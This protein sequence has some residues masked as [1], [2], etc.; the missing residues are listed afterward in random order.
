[1]LRALQALS[2]QTLPARAFEVI[3][4]IDGSRDR[5]SE[6]VA[7]FPAPYLLR[8]LWQPNS[9]RASA[10]NSGILASCGK[11]TVLLDDDMEPLPGCLQAH[12][13]AHESARPRAVMGAVP[14][15]LDEHS[16][17]T[18]R[19][20]RDRF[21]QHSMKLAQP[22]YSIGFRD[23]Y[24]GNLSVPR[25]VL[26]E[27][28]LF[29]PA[30]L[31]YGNEDGELALRLIRAGVELGYSKDAAAT[32]HYEK[33]FEALARDNAA[34]GRTAVLCLQRHPETIGTLQQR[35]YQHGSWKWWTIRRLLLT[36]T[37]AFQSTPALVIRFIHWQERRRSPQLHRYYRLA[38]DYFFWL[39]AGPEL[40]LWRR[41][42]GS[43]WW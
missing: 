27:V 14:V 34:K 2:L 35:L 16:P 21:E 15:R 11:L 39:G 40:K 26:I 23:F 38:L 18:A 1:V 9:G 25:N 24:S 29:D 33:E 43:G 6:L 12:C 5:T 19:F 20:I 36:V 4:S 17:L 37:A 42:Q 32:Q 8:T 3:V 13:R 30:F 31:A 41:R 10:C 22:D 7:Q 28:G